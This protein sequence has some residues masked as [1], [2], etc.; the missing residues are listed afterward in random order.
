MALTPTVK[1]LRDQRHL[2]VVQEIAS[3][4]FPFP[5][6]Q[7]P[8]LETIVN[9]PK[10]FMSAGTENGKDIFPDIVVVRRPGVWLQ[11][12]AL[13]ETADTINDETATGRW[14]PA[15]KCGQLYLYVPNGC[16]GEAKKVAKRN[17]VAVAGYRTWRFR[18]VWGLEVAEA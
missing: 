2:G 18:P 15:S 14:L 7:F 6:E 17:H 4:K 16:V 9:V 12:M 1:Y 11:M 3:L 8:D 10:G 5:S 13:V